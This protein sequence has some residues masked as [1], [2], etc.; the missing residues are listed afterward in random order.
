MAT[1]TEQTVISGTFT[2]S[3]GTVTTV[4]NGVTTV[5][6]P[7][8]VSVAGAGVPPGGDAGQ[9]LSK[10][11]STDYNTEWVDKND[12]VWGSITGTLSDQTD[13]Y[14]EIDS[15]IGS[16]A[17]DTTPQLSADLDVNGNNITSVSNLR[18]TT[19]VLQARHPGG[20]TFDKTTLN[21]L[22]PDNTGQTN[23]YCLIQL[24]NGKLGLQYEENADKVTISN[25]TANPISIDGLNYPTADGSDGDVLTTDGAGNLTLETISITESQISDF[26]TYI[27][28]SEKAAANGVATLGADSKVP[29]NQLPGLALTDVNTVANQTEQLALTAQEGDLAIRTDENKSYVHNGGSVGDMTDWSEL[30]TP[31][32]AVLSVDG[33]TGTVTLGDLYAALVHTHTESEITDLD[34]YTQA[35]V[36][37]LL[38]AQ[39]H[40]ESDITDLDKYTQAEVDT[41]LSGKANTSHTH[42][43]ADITD[44][45][46]YIEDITGE[47]LTDLS[48]VPA[49]TGNQGKLLKVNATEDGLIWGDPSG[50]S[51]SWGDIAGTLSDQTDL[52]TALDGKSNTT[53][54]HTKADITDFNENDYATGA[55][56]DLATSALQPGDN[57][58]ELVNDAGY[59]T[60]LGGAIS[61]VVEDTTPQLGGHLDAQDFNINNGGNIFADNYSFNG[62]GGLTAGT[63]VTTLASETG[64]SLD[65]RS[66][67][68]LSIQSATGGDIELTPVGGG[69]IELKGTV[70]IQAG[71]NLVSSDLTPISVAVDLDMGTN[72]ITDAKV[73][74]WDT[75]YG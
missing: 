22:L 27:P 61:N 54:T 18:L 64:K 70:S 42:V 71:N 19:P 2:E 14:T 58:S 75:A 56:G 31:T 1:F 37:A 33:R 35:E 6:A 39:T 44:L 69:S 23:K 63:H 17:E 50:G 66:D 11:N 48:D 32:D 10:I 4:D 65:V 28:T 34:K 57:I 55:E 45:G 30:L 8:V 7:T 13:L 47:S 73:G 21:L 68:T 38:S 46:A 3:D 52:Q 26:G 12:A 9:L 20:G 60:S 5:T 25:S 67:G 72:T 43:E 16:L 29:S 74:Q 24:N 51:I 40:T 15:K 49:L 62:G 36:N 41:L 53:H 59:I